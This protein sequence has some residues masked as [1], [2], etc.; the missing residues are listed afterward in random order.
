MGIV[1]LAGIAIGW[2]LAESKPRLVLANGAD[3][4]GDRALLSGSIA[5]E[6]TADKIPVSQDALY[7]LNYST[8]KL[9]A[10]VP[11]LQ[12]TTGKSSVFGDFAERDLIADFGI[13]PGQNPHFLMTTA[14]LGVRT[15]GWSPLFVVE[16]ETGQ[17]ASYKVSSQNTIGST[18][19][20]FQLL[21]RRI[22]RRLGK[23]IE[24]SASR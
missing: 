8:G 23:A 14:S 11:S 18:R 17:V 9:M 15:A 2:F 3:R 5:V 20:T 24:A 10:S 7:Y 6:L 16:T 19:P 4:W 22:D 12:Q 21:D 13:K 1:L